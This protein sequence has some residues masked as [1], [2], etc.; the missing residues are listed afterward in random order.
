LSNSCVYM[1]KNPNWIDLE[2]FTNASKN[3]DLEQKYY[4]KWCQWKK[5]KEILQEDNTNILIHNLLDVEQ[6][7]NDNNKSLTITP[8]EGFRLLGLF[9]DTYSEKK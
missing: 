1:C 3:I 4:W 2:E 9:Q 6:F 8:S 7:V 5:F